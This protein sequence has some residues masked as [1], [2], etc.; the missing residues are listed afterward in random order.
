MKAKGKFGLVVLFVFLVFVSVFAIPATASKK[1]T[2]NRYN[3]CFVLDS[4]DS[5]KH[6][7]EDKLR[8]DATNMFLGLLANEGNYVGSV[9][10]SGGVIKK[11]DVVPING[12][13]DKIQSEKALETSE[14]RGATAIGAALDQAI[15]LLINKGDKKL[16][17]VVILLSDGQSNKS[18]KDEMD[19]RSNALTK[20]KNE[21]IP[22]Y[23]VALN[24]DGEA[25]LDVLQQIANATGGVY[26]EVKKADDLKDIFK[27]F[28]KMIYAAGA[29]NLID[30][31]IP[32]SGKLSVNFDV[33]YKGVEEVNIIISSDTKLKELILIK[34]SGTEM[35]ENEVQE[36]TVNAKRFSITKLTSPEG[37]KWTL[38][39][40]GAPGSKIKIDMV[41]N[42]SITVST[43]YKEK[44]IYGTNEKVT[45]KGFV[46]EDG[47]KLS[48][49]YD[50]YK[51]TLV[52]DTDKG[53][54]ISMEIKED[55]F[56]GDISFD[57][58]GTYSYHMVV[59]GNGLVKT[60]DKSDIV[61]NVGNRAP[62]LS[63]DAKNMEEHFWVFPFFTKTCEVDLSKA[64]SDPDGDKIT[65]V[66]DSSTFK[67][68]TYEINGNKLIVKDFYDLS[69]GVTTIKA[70]DSKGASVE[71]DTTVSLTNVGILA[72][73]LIGVGIIV[74]LVIIGIVT[75]I[76]LNK[77][78]MGS[79]TVRNIET[80]ETQMQ[81][82]NRGKIKLS[83]FAI[84]NTGHSSKAYF[85]ATGKDKI[86]FVTNKAVKADSNYGTSK[87]VTVMNHLETIIYS[88]AECSRGI[89]V[90]FDSFIN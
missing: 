58:E 20:A 2:S 70:I 71:F 5:L 73:I 26:K 48:S 79:I 15:D 74:F 4:T 47:K 54:E 10:F 62:V 80:G 53:N 13:K 61:F 67:E 81:Q 38:K 60:T 87:K 66:A 76:A 46:L 29:Q 69:K 33:P 85:Q 21:S 9:I 23:T 84:G 8:Y 78:F 11:S 65:F 6:T 31:T 43:E 83:T 24:A 25:D 72:L 18:D 16:P 82:R 90:T 42:D 12:P 86:I 64:V 40:K 88:D 36:V 32:S 89:S 35:S 68:S 77:K 22:V 34:P 75:Y 17:S 3:V 39:G 7:D 19:S 63:N 55:S 51:A 49:G 56:V 57:D 44:D 37:G 41:Y 52:P 50:D 45:V 28:Y 1:N 14:Q 59:E 30:S 27:E